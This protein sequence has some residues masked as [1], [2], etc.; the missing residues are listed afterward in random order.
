MSRMHRYVV[1]ALVV[2]LALAAVDSTAQDD[3]LVMRL[4][5][6]EIQTRIDVPKSLAAQRKET[7]RKLM[8]LIQKEKRY[9]DFDTTTLA[10]QALGTLR[11]VEA[12][13]LLA[14]YI[15]VK[16]TMPVD[17]LSIGAY[18]PAAAALVQIGS[19]ALPSILRVITEADDQRSQHLAGWSISEI[20]GT[21][22]A[23][24]Y[25]EQQGTKSTGLAAQRIKNALDSIETHATTIPKFE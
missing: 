14:G 10:I 20:L 12:A 16:S 11:A 3:D 22:L 8:R 9:Q 24:S 2:G 1:A 17:E 19:P 25:L 23:A 18:F 5:S 13:D 21:E 6:P 15:A 4:T 7:I